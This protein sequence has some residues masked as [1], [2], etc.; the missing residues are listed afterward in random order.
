MSTPGKLKPWQPAAKPSGSASP[1][2]K[3]AADTKN[4]KAAPSASPKAN[5]VAGT[6]AKADLP[7]KP[8]ASQPAKGAPTAGS[9]VPPTSPPSDPLVERIRQDWIEAR[10]DASGRTYYYNPKT[11]KTTTDLRLEAIIAF[12]PKV[13]KAPDAASA[14]A[15]AAKPQGAGPSL[16]EQLAASRALNDQYELEV[17]Y[18]RHCLFQGIESTTESP[19]ER[20]DDVAVLRARIASLQ[21]LVQKQFQQL[22][23]D[24]YKQF[25]CSKCEKLQL[26]QERSLTEVEFRERVVHPDYGAKRT[27]TYLPTSM[28][29]PAA[30]YLTSHAPIQ[31]T[32]GGNHANALTRNLPLAASMAQHSSPPRVLGTNATSPL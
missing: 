31:C 23:V 14:A 13:E 7:N 15:V 5:I 3:P 1:G 25:L 6:P 20:C 22:Q 26:E 12:S 32:V 21:R 8:Q 28:D 16:E 29:M 2:D 27:T 17:T 4:Q 30:R 10:D 24:R 9:A 18:L 19:L 11:G